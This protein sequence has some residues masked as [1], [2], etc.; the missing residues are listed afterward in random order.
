MGL[1]ERTR[2][3]VRL[4]SLL[5]VAVASG[6]IA[7]S[8]HAQVILQRPDIQQ[9]GL[10]GPPPLFA[11][12]SPAL[13]GAQF[14]VVSIKPHPYDPGAGGGMRTLPDGTFMMTGQSIWS[15]ISSV[16]PVP[17]SPRDTIGLPDWARTERYDII[18]KVAPGSNPTREQ[19]AEMM[20]NMLVERLKVVSHIEEQ[21]RTTFSLV[22]AR[23]DGRLGPQLKKSIVDCTPPSSPPDAAPQT[24]PSAAIRCGMRMGPGT[25][26]ANGMTLDRL[27][28]S[29]SGLAGGRVTNLTGLDGAYD[30][31]LHFAPPRLN[32]D[33]SAPAD[34]AP[35]FVTALQEQLGLKLVPGK[36]MVKI[37]VI[38][39]IERPTPNQ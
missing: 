35:Q 15:I 24:R 38:D 29:L 21:E 27:V 18:A 11:P 6:C 20:R 9:L 7:A 17:V 36:S 3:E 23:S 25:I 39:H 10:G 26:E 19:R 2:T 32:P 13:S 8:A 14:D 22:V 37:L 5:S 34:D 28:N 1:P 16:S 30:L 31:T 4:R 33:P 12:Q